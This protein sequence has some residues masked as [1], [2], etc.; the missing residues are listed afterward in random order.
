MKTSELLTNTKACWR[1]ISAAVTMVCVVSM[2]I[3]LGLPLLSALMIEHKASTSLIGLNG[4]IGGVATIIAAISVPTLGKNFKIAPLLLL[5]LACGALSFLGFYF[6]S[7]IYAWLLLRFTLHFSLTVLFILSECWINQAASNDKRGF[8]LA[9]YAT[10]FGLG[11]AIGPSLFAFIGKN[12]IL[13]FLLGASLVLLAAIPIILSWHLSPCFQQEGRTSF[14]S[15]LLKLPLANLAVLIF[16]ALQIGA[17]NL[18]VPFITQIGYNDLSAG[19]FLTI[20]ALGNMILLI[21]IGI[22]SDKLK[23]R[24]LTLFLCASIGFVGALVLPIFAH[25]AILLAADLFLLGGVV[26]GL[27][28]I[29]LTVLGEKYRG[30]ELAT[31]NSALIFYYGVGS[32]IGPYFIGWAMNIKELNPYGFAWGISILFLSYLILMTGILGKKYLST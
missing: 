32:L 30:K 17:I 19:H 12:G 10:A 7:N 14:K 31:A 5:M 25:S 29:A 3:G 22:L 2:V 9:I 20:M 1:S 16:G 26:S 6:F 15:Y 27:Y 13:P 23:N 18:I 24:Y 11:F 21:P 28:T 8:A 4:T